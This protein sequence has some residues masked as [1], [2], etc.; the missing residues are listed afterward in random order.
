MD[1]RF[2]VTGVDLLVVARGFAEA[3]FA[4]AA[5]F[6]IGATVFFC[7]FLE[8]AA[9]LVLLTLI[10]VAFAPFLVDASSLSSVAFLFLERAAAVFVVGVAGFLIAEVFFVTGIFLGMAFVLVTD[11]D[12]AAIWR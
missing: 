2:P 10:G 4:A 8:G 6:V 3:R 9:V 1:L 11:A 12:L 5:A 7:A